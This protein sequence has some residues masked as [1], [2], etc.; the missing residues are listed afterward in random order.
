MDLGTIIGIGMSLVIVVV[1]MILDG[2]SPLELLSHPSAILLTLGG[3]MVATIAT[4]PFE[5]LR[6]LVGVDEHGRV[7]L[8]DGLGRQPHALRLAV[9]PDG[10]LLQVRLL[11]GLVH[12]DLLQADAAPLLGRALAGAA[13]GAP[14]LLACDGTNARHVVPP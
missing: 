2:G 1:V 14:G 3:S 13:G 8:A 5:A 10:A 9:D 6:Q 12:A 7:E 4:M 11:G